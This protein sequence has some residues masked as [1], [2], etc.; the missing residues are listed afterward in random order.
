M[1]LQPKS[2]IVALKAAEQR[3]TI[4][5]G[6]KL[7]K[8]VDR[9]RE[10]AAD[11]EAALNAFRLRTI[12]TINAEITEATEKK[13]TL[14][15]E[16]SELEKR[17]AEAF[18]PLREKEQELRN[19]EAQLIEEWDVLEKTN[20]SLCD[21]EQVVLT[22]E[23]V[24]A[25]LEKKAQDLLDVAEVKLREADSKEQQAE[26]LLTAFTVKD[27]E[28]SALKQKLEIEVTHREQDCINREKS[29]IIRETELANGQAELQ[30]GWRLLED[31]KAAFERTI[32]RFNT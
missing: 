17:R 4:A 21:R 16:V 32:K 11:E 24:S 23:E 5:E 2:A 3:Q 20:H 10:V 13:E 22:K 26:A 9:L 19:K 31:R 29:L 6:L 14:L 25:A 7:S 28:V 12:E 27:A 8:R 15:G 18:V 1:K 30:N